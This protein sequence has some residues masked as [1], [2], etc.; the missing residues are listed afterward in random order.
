MRD[1]TG[2]VQH[3][4]CLHGGWVFDG[5]EP[6]AFPLNKESLDMCTREVR[7]GV[8]QETLEFVC[9]ERGIQFIWHGRRELLKKV[10]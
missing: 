10:K 7:D 8:N 5:N 2:S 1:T 3:A 6:Y 9:F 4:V